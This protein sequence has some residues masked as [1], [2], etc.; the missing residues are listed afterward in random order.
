MKRLFVFVP[1]ILP[2][3][4][5]LNSFVVK[6]KEEKETEG[7]K[8][9]TGLTL[10][11]NASIGPLG[12][13]PVAKVK[14]KST[15]AN[16]LYKST[17]DGQTWQDISEGLPE[18]EQPVNFSAGASDLYLRVKNVMYRSKSDLKAPVWEKTDVPDPQNASSRP[19]T[20]ITFNPSGVMTSAAEAW[21][22]V[23]T[24]FKENSGRTILETSDG[25]V[26]LGYDH[27]LYRSIDKGKNWKQVQ[28]EGWVMNMLESEG[29]LIATGTKGIMRSTDNGEHWKWVIKEGGA[30]IAVEHIEGGFAAIAYNTTTKSRRIHISLDN[31]KTWKV[32]SDTLGP[33][34]SISSI[35]QMGKYLIC[36]HPDG[37]FRS[38]DMGK[39][40]TSVHSSV[41]KVENKDF[42]FVLPWNSP[43][44][45]P[46]NVFKIFVSG[47]VLYALAVSAGC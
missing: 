24:N 6:E 47:D 30:G 1:A 20:S 43:S 15:R 26:F 19:S 36:G 35:K 8:S 42:K 23:Y 37:I 4:F 41:D 21:S 45:Q 11:V 33:S 18:I 27:G 12:K 44:N 9:V 14:N 3:L 31:G 29:V 38:S 13:V 16:I 5:L 25:T 39:T 17:D 46:K 28:K 32:I 22:P 7:T 10:L 40:W 2:A 34:P